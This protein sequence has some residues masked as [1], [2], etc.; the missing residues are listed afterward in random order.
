MYTIVYSANSNLFMAI[1]EVE[2]KVISLKTKGYVEQGS[3]SV[4][5]V[6]IDG[7]Y[8]VAQAMIKND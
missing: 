6:G 8:V 1:T 3:V 4:S 5:S 2:K 7:L